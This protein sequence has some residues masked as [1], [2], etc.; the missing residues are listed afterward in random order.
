MLHVLSKVFIA[1]ISFVD[2]ARK[3]VHVWSQGKSGTTR[4]MLNIK[5]NSMLESGELNGSEAFECEDQVSVKS[6]E[7]LLLTHCCW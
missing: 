4:I 6:R 3:I 5:P 7:P 2:L 1:G